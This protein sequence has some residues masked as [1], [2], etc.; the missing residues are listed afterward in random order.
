MQ[1]PSFDIQI[2]GSRGLVPSANYPPGADYAS[3]MRNL[4][5]SPYAAVNPEWPTAPLSTVVSWPFPQIF[6]GEN[7]RFS[8]GSTTVSTCVDSS[9]AT[10]WTPTAVT[11]K[12]AENQAQT[13]TIT[14]GGVWHVA[15]FEEVAF[16][17]NGTSLLFKIPAYA[18]WLVPTGLSASTLCASGDRLI[19]AGLSGTWFAGAAWQRLFKRWRQTQPQ[20]AHDQ[21]TWSNRWVMW[22][23]RLGGSRDIPFWP[24]LAALGCFGDSAFNMLEAEFLACV[25]RGELGFA[26][27]R[28]AGSVLAALPLGNDVALYSAQHKTL[29]R[30]GSGLNYDITQTPNAGVAGRG[31]VTGDEF[32]HAWVDPTGFLRQQDAGGAVQDLDQAHRFTAPATLVGSFD[33]DQREYW[34]STSTAAYVLNASGLGGPM[35]ICPTSLCRVNGTLFG[36]GNGLFATTVPVE[37]YTHTTDMRYRGSKRVNIVEWATRGLTSL[38]ADA[39]GDGATLGAVPCNSYGVGHPKRSANEFQIGVKGTGNVGDEYAVQRGTVRF[40]AEDRRFRPG[41]GANAEDS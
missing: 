26:S 40:Q 10:T 35:D 12:K 23:E 30:P 24:M 11:P 14:A 29:L 37:F 2:P 15:T 36:M 5:A 13:A 9:P 31:A 22:G 16:A 8:L 38:Y 34:F 41:P 18:N 32:G 3:R 25:E 1:T 21:M 28:R 17:T 39:I 20:F 7:I 33:P 27:V 19:L 4:R 6:Q